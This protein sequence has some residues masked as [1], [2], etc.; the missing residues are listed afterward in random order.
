[1]SPSFLPFNYAKWQNDEMTP[2]VEVAEKVLMKILVVVPLRS[3]SYM[4][5]CPIPM[6]GKGGGESVGV[7]MS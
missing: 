3:D 4:P 2:N 7:M 5:F 6:A 1:V